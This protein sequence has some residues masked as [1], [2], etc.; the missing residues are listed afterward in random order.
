MFVMK[1]VY[2]AASVSA[3]LFMAAVGW[4]LWGP[5]RTPSG[6]PPLTTLHAENFESFEKAFN[7]AMGSVRIVLLLSPS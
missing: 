7:Q 3:L 6:Q 4:Y 2:G 5:S 1:K